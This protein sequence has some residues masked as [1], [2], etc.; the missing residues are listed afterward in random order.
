MYGFSHGEIDR[1]STY[2]QQIAN[3]DL[4]PTKQMR[5][6]QIIET[7]QMQDLLPSQALIPF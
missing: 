1:I 3:L 5:E 4:Y 2:I 6:M 7:I